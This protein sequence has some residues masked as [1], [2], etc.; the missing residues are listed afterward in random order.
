MD[1]NIKYTILIR[2]KLPIENIFPRTLKPPIAA[3][4]IP[5]Y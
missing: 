2:K 4:S 3:D 1:I 5:L